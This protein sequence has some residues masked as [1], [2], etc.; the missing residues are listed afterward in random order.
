M[1]AQQ[2]CRKEKNVATDVS[3]MIRRIPTY[4]LAS[5]ETKSIPAELLKNDEE[6]GFESHHSTLFTD[7]IA[8]D[9]EGS[10]IRIDDIK[11]RLTRQHHDILESHFQTNRKP[12]TR[13][14]R[15]LAADLGVPLDKVNVSNLTI[16]QSSRQ[17]IFPKRSNAAL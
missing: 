10:P 4:P 7:C 13:F 17:V 3:S 16:I 6:D 15:N 11:P 14:K 2:R 9:A 5:Y 1:E 12:S 8:V